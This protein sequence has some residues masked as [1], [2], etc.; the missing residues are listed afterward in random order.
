MKGFGIY[1][2]NDLLEKKHF[3]QMGIT[4]WLYLWFLDKMTSISEDG[5]GLV[6]GGKP[7]TFSDVEE[8]LGI[9]D[10]TY[11]RW[12]AVLKKYEYINVIRTPHGLRVTVNRAVKK[13]GNKPPKSRPCEWCGRKDLALVRH[14]YPIHAEDGGEETV[15]ICVVCHALYHSMG[16]PPENPIYRDTSKV[17]YQDMEESSVKNRKSSQYLKDV[18]KDSTKTIQ[19]TIAEPSVPPVFS[20][21]EYLKKMQVDKRSSIRFIAYFFKLRNLTFDSEDQVKVAIRRHIRAATDVVKFGDAA[22]REAVSKCKEMG[23]KDNIAWTIET[24]LKMLTK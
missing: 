1:V 10:S 12:I 15:C 8:E 21:K 9:T 14:H 7:I 24:V 4:I 22:V 2:K 11:S 17:G 20:F 13:F 19:K 23:E 3:D 18:N 5:I 16:L 6:L